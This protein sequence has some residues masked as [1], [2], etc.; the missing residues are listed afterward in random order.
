M[1]PRAWQW[2]YRIHFGT[3]V[4]LQ[5]GIELWKWNPSLFESADGIV[6]SLSR[7]AHPIDDDSICFEATRSLLDDVVDAAGGVERAL[8]RLH[9]SIDQARVVY[10]R[11]VE[12]H[13]ELMEG[14]GL[15]G[16]STE[17]AGTRSRSS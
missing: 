1:P 17:D 3:G 12:Q 10:A 5:W 9:E 16:P 8:D 15:S 7:S 4:G 14:G 6:A 11:A 2:T 13:G